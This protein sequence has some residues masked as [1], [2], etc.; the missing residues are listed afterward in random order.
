MFAILPQVD[1]WEVREALSLVTDVCCRR[2]IGP[3]GLG[4]VAQTERRAEF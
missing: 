4:G 2:G 3:L 1:Q